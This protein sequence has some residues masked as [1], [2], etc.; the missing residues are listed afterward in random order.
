MATKKKKTKPP[1]SVR[2]RKGNEDLRERLEVLADGKG[3]SF[4]EFVEKILETFAA[5]PFELK[6]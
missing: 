2:P 1:F 4:N 5:N 3:R 6:F